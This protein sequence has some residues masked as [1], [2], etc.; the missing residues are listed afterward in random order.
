MALVEQEQAHRINYEDTRLA[1]KVSGSKR[2]HLIGGAITVIAILAAIIGAY[3]GV[4]P[5]VCV[6]VV[7]LP[8]ASILR[9][10]F[11]K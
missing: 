10:I 3:L 4:S 11:G 5:I 9:S 2:G 1:G 8:I 7:S 6:A